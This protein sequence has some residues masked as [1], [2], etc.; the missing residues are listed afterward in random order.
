M[1]ILCPNH[2]N[3]YAVKISDRHQNLVKKVTKVYVQHEVYS[4]PGVILNYSVLLYVF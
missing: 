3:I 1:N 4:I 2:H